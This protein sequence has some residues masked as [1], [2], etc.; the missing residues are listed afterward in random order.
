MTVVVSCS[1]MNSG[2][3]WS[4]FS[5][6]VVVGGAIG[7]IVGSKAREKH[8]SEAKTVDTASSEGNMKESESPGAK[9]M[10]ARMVN[11]SLCAEKKRAQQAKLQESSE[12]FRPTIINQYPEHSSES[13]AAMLFP[14]TDISP[15]PGSSPSSTSVSVSPS[16]LLSKLS[17]APTSLHAFPAPPVS[18]TSPN[19]G[20][21]GKRN[22]M[23]NTQLAALVAPGSYKYVLAMVGLPARGKSYLV[24][25][26]LRYLR[27]TGIEAEIFNVG[28]F[29]RK[30]GMGAV[31]ST[32]FDKNNTD[33][34]LQREKLAQDVQDDMYRWLHERTDLA[35]AFFDA[36]NTTKARR[37]AILERV[38]QEPNTYLLFVESICDN[39]II[40]ERN[41]KM[42]LQNQDYKNQDPELALA[43][44]KQRVIEY[45]SVY[46][47]VTDEE[48]RGRAS[49]IKIYNVGEKVVTRRCSGYIPSQVAF[50][51][52]N[53]HISPRK[54]WLTQHAESLDQMRGLLGGDSGEMTSHGEEYALKLAQYVTKSIA[55]LKTVRR[56][57]KANSS[58]TSN[59]DEYRGD[60]LVVMLGTQAIHHSTVKHLMAM[61]P[62]VKF[63]SNSILNELRGGELDKMSHR[64]IKEKFPEIWEERM[65]DKLHFR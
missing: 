23:S 49:Y 9:A 48:D 12:L 13:P 30:R 58:N 50:H 35:V 59:D 61:N 29:R 8:D 27:W 6:G 14:S 40:L 3:K 26:I 16:P 46:E 37:A 19:L 42:K 22:S 20:K 43:D 57:E 51:L 62:D 52:M 18:S 1:R 39:P 60:E 44:F 53:V 41:Y 24:K 31:P 28:N 36:T 2:T 10:T 32:F 38:K 56:R 17:K 47:E 4:L 25:M 63:V 34:Q 55:E 15:P 33:A 64:E 45:E 54:I 7:V 5:I 21:E 11:D 65:K